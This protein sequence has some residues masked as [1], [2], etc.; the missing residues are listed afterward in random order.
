MTVTP[1]DRE[2]RAGEIAD[3]LCQPSSWLT[4]GRSI[5]IDE[6]RKLKLEVIDYSTKPELNEAIT[7]Y[8]I[9]LS[10]LFDSTNIYKLVETPESQI[11]RHAVNQTGLPPIQPSF[12][13]LPGQ[14]VNEVADINYICPR[15]KTNM[16]IQANLDNHSN[17]KP[18]FLPFPVDNNIITCINCGFNSN[19]SALRLQIEAQTIK[20]IVK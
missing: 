12:P 6:I 10:I 1:A 9:L 11:Y 7:R 3:K 18:G 16:K 5:N 14:Q 8:F 15:C 2:E 4:H 17:L 19:L 20:K 13:L